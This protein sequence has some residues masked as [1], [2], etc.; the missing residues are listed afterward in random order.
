M[1]SGP[2][3]ILMSCNVPRRREGGAAAII[4]NLSRELERRGHNVRHLFQEDLIDREKVTSR[5]AEL[6]FSIRLGRYIADHRGEFDIVNLHAP[7]GFPYGLRRR[8]FRAGGYPPY[9]MTLHGLEE[10]RIH[11]MSRE[12][13]KGRAWHF[14]RKN[15]LW[16]RFYHLPRYRWSIRTADGAHAYSRDVW[17]ILQLK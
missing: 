10:R 12:V 16:E 17:N 15:R 1:T 13:R 7:V 4:Y 3:R 6:I 2:L 5:F 8:L 11:V 9:V 14:S